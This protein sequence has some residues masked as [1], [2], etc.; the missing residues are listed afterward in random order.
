[1]SDIRLFRIHD[2][3]VEPIAGSAVAVE[4]SLQSFIERHLEDLLSIRF[5]ATEFSTTKSHGGRIDTLGIDE[6]NCPVIIEYKRSINENVINQGLFYLDWL[7]DHRA[8]FKLLVLETCGTDAAKTIEW[9]APRL[10]CIAGDFTKYDQHAIKQMPR[11]IDLIRYRKYGDDL[12][13]LEQLATHA[14][15]SPNPKPKTGSTSA[16]D[17]AP[18]H[19]GDLP[20]SLRQLAECSAEVIEWYEELKAFA[21]AL[22]DNVQSY[23]IDRY[24][25][26]R[27]LK[28]FAYIRFRPTIGKIVVDL[29][30]SA[31]T[32][33]AN[34]DIVRIL[35]SEGKWP[36][37]E[38]TT[39][40]QLKRVLLLIE[41]SYQLT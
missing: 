15:E 32:L 8:D 37:A 1:M 41:E 12:I 22:G 13:L 39:H 24:V 4:K 40:E 5:L 20:L 6:N 26:F 3:Q 7:L 33:E 2:D 16:G 27:S 9:G 29:R 23:A 30:L 10:I 19:P 18:V 21:L 25:S 35:N 38:I 14:V 28:N 11:N 36:R 34:R 31:Q 17:P